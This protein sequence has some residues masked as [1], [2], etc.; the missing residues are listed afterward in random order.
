MRGITLALFFASCFCTD[1]AWAIDVRATGELGRRASWQVPDAE[2]VKQDLSSWL[3]SRKV[4]V[5]QREQIE[6]VW[7][8]TAASSPDV[9]ERTCRAIASA[10]PRAN[11]ML[12]FCSR[13]RVGTRL[14]DAAWLDSTDTA[15]FERSNMR[16]LY[17]RWLAQHSLYDEAAEQLGRLKPDDVVDPASLLFY[18]AVVFHQAPEKARAIKALERLLE[19]EGRIPRRFASLARL[20]QADLAPLKEESLDHI[21]RRMND[22]RRRLDLGHAGPKVQ[23]VEDGVIKSLDKLIDELEKQQQ[24]AAAAAAAA[25]QQNLRPSSPAQQSLPMGGKGEGKVARKDVGNQSGWGE[26]PP[27]QRQEA[28][29]QIGKDFPSHY[30]EVV[31]QYFR[32]LATQDETQNR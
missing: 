25:A 6:S 22:V 20:M 16:L 15:V 27:K 14:P 4:P 30:R 10:D 28:L 19:N 5:G 23:K 21:S 17:G 9:L 29:Q 1:V 8:S 24:A 13:G 3:E 12:E 18:Q 31:E 7:S 26:L 2:H 32:K 11:E